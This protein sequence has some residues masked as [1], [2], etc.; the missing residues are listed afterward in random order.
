MR[1]I[2]VIFITAIAY[3]CYYDNEE[4]LYPQLDTTCDTA[5]VAFSSSV[6]PVLEQNC[7]S[8]HSNNTASSLG[9]NIKL[10]DYQDV[11]LRADNGSLLGTISHESGYS[12]MPKG[13][14]RLNNCKIS[15]IKIWIS[16]GAPD[17]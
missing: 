12:P 8:C 2:I 3:G 1:I 4:Y 6:K 10:E 17:N 16:S 9:G 5:D 11:R 14:S 7:L 15:I 13:A